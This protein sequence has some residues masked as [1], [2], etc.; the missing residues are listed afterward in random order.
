MAEQPQG[1]SE[2][3]VLDVLKTI[4]YPGYNRDIVAFGM[5]QGIQVTGQNVQVTLQITSNQENIAARL[6]EI[7]ETAL[8]TL[9]GVGTATVKVRLKSEA[10]P[11]APQNRN[12]FSNAAA[13]P[14]VQNIIAVAS[15]KGGVGKSTVATNLAV[16]LGRSSDWL[17]GCRYLWS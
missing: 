8:R 12:P 4:T 16:A 13:L 9:P 5:V 6:Q 1:L 2:P 7:T 15:G 17:T 14:G 10:E 11:G 3:Q